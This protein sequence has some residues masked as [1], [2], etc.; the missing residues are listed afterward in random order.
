MAENECCCTTPEYTIKLSQQGPPG[1]TGEPGADGFSPEIEVY[2][3]DASTYRLSITTKDGGLITPNLKGDSVPLGGA[4][5]QILMKQSGADLDVAWEDFP[6][7]STSSTGV[8]RMATAD[9]F[10]EPD[11]DAYIAVNPYILTQL[12]VLS[13]DVRTLLPMSESDYEDL[14]TP[15]EHTLYLIVEE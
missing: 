13:E 12:G 2:Q 11:E 3:N 6:L 5:G 8:V 1:A 7:A 4:E 10:T 14:D 15:D 9:D